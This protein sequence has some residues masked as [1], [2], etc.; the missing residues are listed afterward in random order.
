[1][2]AGQSVSGGPRQGRQRPP[3]THNTS[4]PVL[5]ANYVDDEVLHVRFPRTLDIQRVHNSGTCWF[6]GGLDLSRKPAVHT[7][8]EHIPD[9]TN[10]RNGGDLGT[11]KDK[12]RRLGSCITLRVIDVRLHRTHQEAFGSS[13]CIQAFSTHMAL[14]I[15]RTALT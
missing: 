7:L 5:G 12:C 1:M 9:S 8:A 2:I 13:Q 10:A 11:T 4:K 15:L 3:G 14:H 6:S